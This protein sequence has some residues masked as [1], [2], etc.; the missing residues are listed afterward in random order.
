MP[1]VALLTDFGSADHYV[2]ALKGA[3]L[4][5]CPEA[6]IIDIAHDLLAHD[7]EEGAWCLAAA[8]R[9]F[10]PRTV[11]VAVVDPGVGSSRRALAIECGEALFVGPDNGIF[12]YVLTENYDYRLREITNRSFM[13]S[14]ISA[15]FHARDVFGPVAAHLAQGVPLDEVGPPAEDPVLFPIQGMRHKG[16][17]EWEAN[18][19]HIDH[20]GNLTTSLYERDLMGILSNAGNDPTEVVVV[21]EGFVIPL[22]HTYSDIAEGEACALVGSTGRM[23]VAVNRGNAARTLGASKGAPVRVRLTRSVY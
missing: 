14:Q 18:V 11:F 23:E 4:S 16:A 22:V 3:I 13:S 7:I 10:P 19:V 6:Q 5:R 2:G 9:S 17:G 12:T 15:T 21:V 8:F 20:F 1:L